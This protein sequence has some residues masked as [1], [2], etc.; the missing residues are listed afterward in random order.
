MGASEK[1]Y[2]SLYTSIKPPGMAHGLLKSIPRL[3]SV[4]SFA[5]IVCKSYILIIMIKS[6]GHKDPNERRL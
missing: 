6:R 5:Q 2:E 4:T 3:I 1:P